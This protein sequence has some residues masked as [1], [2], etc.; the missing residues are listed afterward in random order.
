M[1]VESFGE[2]LQRGEKKQLYS[3]GCRSSLGTKWVAIIYCNFHEGNPINLHYPL[4]FQ[5]FSRIQTLYKWVGVLTIFFV[6]FFSGISEIF[7]ILGLLGGEVSHRFLDSLMPRKIGEVIQFDEDI[8][9]MGG[10]TEPPTI[11]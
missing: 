8:S 7:E 6:F 5:C 2:H 11:I 9:Q 10:W 3:R 4:V 1:L